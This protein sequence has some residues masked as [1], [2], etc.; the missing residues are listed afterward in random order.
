MTAQPRPFGEVVT[1]T[2]S[3]EARVESNL[4]FR[5]DGEIVERLVDTGDRV[6]KGDL[7]ARL[8]QQVQAA[9]VESA[10][11]Q[12]AL[13]NARISQTSAAFTRAQALLERNAGS[14]SDFDEAEQDVKVARADALA[15]EAQLASARESLSYTELRADSDGIIV[16]RQRDVGEVA[17]A[18]ATIFTLAHDGPRD[19]VFNV[20]ESLLFVDQT[21]PTVKVRLASDSSV[22]AEGPI[23]QISP[24]VDAETGTVRIEI[25]LETVPEGMNL[26][27]VVTGTATLPPIDVFEVPVAS[28]TSNKGRPAVWV[29]DPATD[30]LEARTIEVFSYSDDAI[31]AREGLR[32]GDRVVVQGTKLLRERQKIVFDKKEGAE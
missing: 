6:K 26:G 28:L 12:V 11:A 15:A 25:G 20:S 4:S 8:N 21:P 16:S 23:R 1:L 32:A 2:G 24:V 10:Q 31:I 17:A 5:T 22:S 27:A 18:A 13:A 29:V 14:Q 9:E 30:Q 7:L 19:A 3:L